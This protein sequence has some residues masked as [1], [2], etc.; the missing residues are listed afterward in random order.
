MLY[1]WPRDPRVIEGLEDFGMALRQARARIGMSQRQL[2]IGSRVS[3]SVISRAERALTPRLSLER[4]VGI[5]LAMGDEFPLGWCPHHHPCRW[6]P[7]AKRAELLQDYP[8]R[9][10]SLLGNTLGRG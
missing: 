1:M 10:L 7:R 4:V 9:L 5:K 8:E 6:Q 2:C 3:Q